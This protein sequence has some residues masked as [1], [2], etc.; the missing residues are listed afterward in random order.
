MYSADKAFVCEE[1]RPNDFQAENQSVRTAL[2][3]YFQA[4]RF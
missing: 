1:L 3:E 4:E 2:A